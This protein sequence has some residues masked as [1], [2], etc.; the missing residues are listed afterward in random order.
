M[1]PAQPTGGRL[2]AIAIA[3]F[4]PGHDVGLDGEVGARIGVKI[5]PAQLAAEE[6]FVWTV[7]GAQGDLGLPAREVAQFRAH[8]YRQLDLRMTRAKTGQ[9]RQVDPGQRIHGGQP[10]VPGKAMVA[11]GDVA[12]QSRKFR[13]DAARA[14]K[15]PFA[16]GREDDTIVTAV[17]EA[18]AKVRLKFLEFSRHG[19]V[20]NA[21]QSRG[22]GEGA[23]AFKRSNNT[24]IRWLH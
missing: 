11:A 12:L 14:F 5:E 9:R 21:Q 3:I 2:A 16:L 1:D 18:R 23:G 8:L 20:G 24:Q 15:Q 17:G 6:M 22:S 13:F 7:G 10:Y 4:E 19:G